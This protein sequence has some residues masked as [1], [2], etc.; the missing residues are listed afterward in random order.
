MCLLLY[1]YIFLSNIDLY[2][3]NIDLITQ[4]GQ[5]IGEKIPL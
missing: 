2:L 1:I 3:S 4:S 5:I